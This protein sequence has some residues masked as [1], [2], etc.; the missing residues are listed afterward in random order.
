MRRLNLVP[1]TPPS[2]GIGL[3]REFAPGLPSGMESAYLVVPVFRAGGVCCEQRGEQH[4]GVCI[5]VPS[6]VNRGEVRRIAQVGEGEI[7]A[8]ELAPDGCRGKR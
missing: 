3:R 8:A 4:G 5:V 7:V 6:S 1:L 2:R